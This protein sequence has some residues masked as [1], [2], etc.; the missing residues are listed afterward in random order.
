MRLCEQHDSH[1]FFVIVDHVSIAIGGYV[2]CLNMIGVHAGVLVLWGRFQF[3]TYL[4]YSA[5]Y[6]VGTFLAMQVPVVGWTPLKSLEQLGPCA[7]FLGY[8]VLMA[9]EYIRKQQQLTRWEGWKLRMQ[10]GVLVLVVLALGIV[11]LAPKGYFGPLS[12]RVRGLF[13]KHTKTGNPL[14]DSVA[15]HQ[16]ASSK[17]YFQYL[18]HVCSLAPVGYLILTFKLSDA[19]SFLIVWGA[20]SYYFSLKMVRLVLLTAPIGTVLAGIFAG[21]ALAW[22]IAQWWE[23]PETDSSSS[24]LAG[25]DESTPESTSATEKDVAAAAAAASKKRK[26]AKKQSAPSNNNS[27]SSK[28]K[29]HQESSFDGLFQM[30]EAVDAALK[31]PEG[32]SAKRIVS[33]IIVFM[34]YILATKFIPYC[35]ALS[36]QLSHPTV[37]QKARTRDGKIVTI[38]D[39]R[40]AYFWLKDN[41]PEDARIMAW[42]DYGYQIAGIANRTTIADGNTWNHEHIAL[43]GKALTTD[44]ETGYEIARNWV[45]LRERMNSTILAG[46]ILLTISFLSISFAGGLRS[47]VG[48]RRWR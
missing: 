42:W 32:V 23:M 11:F 29:T 16:A 3:T 20:A 26:K 25:S 38:D 34:T 15:E 10:A 1:A 9:T 8:Q 17:A 14:V 36:K 37:I 22:A 45:R 6:V 2:F 30:K 12:S 4:S 31:T 24:S 13:V 39:Y 40:D 47:C 46:I 7:V 28:S 19:T 18:H 48:R 41:T 27:P 5:F 43:L 35:F 44:L 21:R 33:L